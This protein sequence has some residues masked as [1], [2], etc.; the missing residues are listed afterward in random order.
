MAIRLVRSSPEF[1]GAAMRHVDGPVAMAHQNLAAGDGVQPVDG[2]QDGRFARSREPHQHADF[3]RLDGKV[4]ACSPEH[5]AGRLQ[6][7]V[8]GRALVDERQRLA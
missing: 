7:L 4:D 1:V 2:A 6:D 5:G 8:P 3:A